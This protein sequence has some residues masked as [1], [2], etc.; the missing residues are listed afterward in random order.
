MP[1]F[2]NAEPA[3]ITIAGSTMTNTE[4]VVNTIPASVRNVTFGASGKFPTATWAIT[5]SDNTYT[6]V[7][8][9]PIILS[10]VTPPSGNLVA[11]IG[12]DANVPSASWPHY[13]VIP[14]GTT[15][16]LK[17]VNTVSYNGLGVGLNVQGT[18]APESITV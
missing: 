4:P 11:T 12:A 10:V 1:D 5:G 3:G 18:L 13:A 17:I 8:P 15:V 16:T 14:K 2:T 6:F 9:F 7:V